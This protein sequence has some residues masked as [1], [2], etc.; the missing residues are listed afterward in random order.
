MTDRRLLILILSSLSVAVNGLAGE[1]PVPYCNKE[2]LR[3]E[4]KNGV[5]EF[6]FQDDKLAYYARYL[7]AKALLEA[8]RAKRTPKLLQIKT[9]QAVKKPFRRL[10]AAWNVLTGKESDGASTELAVRNQLATQSELDRAEQEAVFADLPTLPEVKKP[11]QMMSPDFFRRREGSV[12]FYGDLALF[13][14]RDHPDKTEIELRN[15]RT[16]SLIASLEWDEEAFGMYQIDG[17]TYDVNTKRVTMHVDTFFGETE[18]TKNKSA[19]M[20]WN[21][22]TGETEKLL[23]HQHYAPVSRDDEWKHRGHHSH[24]YSDLSSEHPYFLHGKTPTGDG[25]HVQ[26]LN[27][28]T[29]KGLTIADA[30]METFS[31]VDHEHTLFNARTQ[32]LTY[33]RKNGL[34]VAMVPFSR[35]E[36]AMNDQSQTAPARAFVHTASVESAETSPSQDYLLTQAGRELNLWNTRSGEK[37]LVLPIHSNRVMTDTRFLPGEKTLLIHEHESDR[38]T[39]VD[40]KSPD[41]STHLVLEGITSDLFRTLSVSTDGSFAIL[42]GANE[43][44]MRIDFGTLSVKPLPKPQFKHV[45]GRSFFDDLIFLSPD[46]TQLYA[47]TKL[48]SDNLEEQFYL[49][50][51]NVETG[52]LIKSEFLLAGHHFHYAAV[53]PDRRYFLFGWNDQE[54]LGPAPGGGTYFRE[55]AKT[56]IFQTSTW[57]RE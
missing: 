1:L 6:E 26:I 18:E 43:N 24:G 25:V 49:E 9:Q 11:R 33:L 54:N 21:T 20:F 5:V 55:H 46:H 37:L 19:F 12:K 34:E 48:R 16:G 57:A 52:E 53:S 30:S 38:L 29:K 8:E 44:W 32:T 28:E 39:I 17:F 2:L 3:P 35:I 10:Q 27:L 36:S 51:V 56:K 14:Y 23:A 47:F 7:K 41:V 22:V 13:V 40:L 42:E 50:V 31:R 4:S 15:L 45:K